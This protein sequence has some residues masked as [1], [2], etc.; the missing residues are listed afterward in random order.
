MLD[1]QILNAERIIHLTEISAINI[2]ATERYKYK[3][4]VQ[5]ASNEGE[6]LLQRDLFSRRQPSWLM[7][8]KNKGD[9]TIAIAFCCREGDITRPWQDVG[10]VTFSTRDY[11]RGD[12]NADLEFPITD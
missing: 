8:L 4:R 3:C 10:R 12:R 7:E 9:C 5:I 2:P 6:T 11:L 1:S